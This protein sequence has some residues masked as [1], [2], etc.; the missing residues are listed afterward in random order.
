MRFEKAKDE[1]IDQATG[2]KAPSRT[3]RGEALRGVVD[4]VSQENDSVVNFLPVH[5]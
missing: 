5:Y 4:N 1:D 2:S 3:G